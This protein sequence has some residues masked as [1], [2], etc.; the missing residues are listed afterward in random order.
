MTSP[1]AFLTETSG[2]PRLL[3]ALAAA[4]AAAAYAWPVTLPP[5]GPSPIPQQ[6]TPAG[7]AALARP[8]FDPGRRPWTARGSRDAVLASDPPRPILTL[9]GIRRDG[10]PRRALIDDGGGEPAWLGQGEGR[11][12]WQVVEVGPDRVKLVQD[13]VTYATEFMGTPAILRPK[14]KAASEAAP[15]LRP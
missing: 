4:A 5:P 12:G 13:G 14:R 15:A 8:L 3:F 7:A 1:T 6:T 2:G 11:N 9:R 10:G